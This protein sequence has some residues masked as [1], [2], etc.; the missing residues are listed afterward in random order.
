MARKPIPSDPDPVLDMSPMIDMSFLLLIY[1]LVTSTLE[2]TE[3]DLAMTMPTS[4]SDGNSK[5][6]IDMMRPQI[7]AHGAQLAQL[8]SGMTELK[9]LLRQT[10]TAYSRH[11]AQASSSP[12]VAPVGQQGHD[13]PQC[14]SV[15][16]VESPCPISATLPFVPASDASRTQLP[17]I[18]GAALAQGVQSEVLALP[19]ADMPGCEQTRHSPPR[20]RRQGRPRSP[21]GSATPLFAPGLPGAGHPLGSLAEGPVA[22][23]SMAAVPPEDI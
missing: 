18:V 19:A 1:F 7:A 6:E 9:A 15:V 20:F 17:L 22:G 23:F 8:A 11:A 2:P 13:A 14:Q 5:V 21:A 12:P 10:L 16:V 4:M 3:A